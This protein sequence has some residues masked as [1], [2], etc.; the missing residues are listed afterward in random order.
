M[1]GAAR[2]QDVLVYP[3]A[4]RRAP[5]P[6]FAELAAATGGRSVAVPDLRTLASSLSTIATELRRQYM[7]GYAPPSSDG[8]SQTWRSIA[9]RVNRPGLRVR[10]RDGYYPGR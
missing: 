6:V 10:A 1:V 2:K 9:V 7:I 3:V 5:P 8:A 4:L